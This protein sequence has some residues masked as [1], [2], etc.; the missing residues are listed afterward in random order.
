MT[1]PVPD[2]G[3]DVRSHPAGGT[4]TISNGTTRR[5]LR[6]AVRASGKALAAVMSRHCRARMA[7]TTSCRS[8]ARHRSRTTPSIRRCPRPDVAWLRPLQLVGRAFVKL[9][10]PTPDTPREV[11]CLFREQQ[12]DVA[13]AQAGHVVADRSCPGKRQ[14]CVARDGL[15]TPA[16]P[17]NDQSSAGSPGAA[18]PHG[19]VPQLVVVSRRAHR[20]PR[21]D[22]PVKGR[23]DH[24]RPA[25]GRRERWKIE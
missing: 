22:P 7:S 18:M 8:T 10:A 20:F 11:A 5:V 2:P 24:R 17:S 19:L 23:V 4:G 16:A 6:H 3:H 21:A 12:S 9:H 14:P 15:F 25:T 1:P 13:Q